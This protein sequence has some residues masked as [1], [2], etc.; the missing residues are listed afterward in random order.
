MTDRSLYL[1]AYDVSDSRRLRASL[2]LVKAFA[3][4]GQ[5]SFYEIFLTPAEKGQL[6]HDMALVLD[7]TQ[8]RFFLLRLDPRSRV[9]ALGAAIEPTDLSYFYFG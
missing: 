8:D 1:A 9:Y 3:T 4:G 5:K 6:L 2:D 7:A